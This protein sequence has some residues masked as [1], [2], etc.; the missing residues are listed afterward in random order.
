MKRYFIFIL[1]A[2]LLFVSCKS[3]EPEAIT[4]TESITPIVTDIVEPKDPF[5]K[6][7][8][9]ALIKQKDDR[10]DDNYANWLYDNEKESLFSVLE[11]TNEY[12]DRIWYE[13]TGSSFQ[14][15]KHLSGSSEDENVYVKDIVGNTAHLG[16]AGDVSFAPDYSHA[17]AYANGGL[18]N[19]FPGDIQNAMTTPDIFMVNNEFCYSDR[20]APQ[21]GKTYTFRAPP[22]R[23]NWLFEMGVDIVS[24][25]NNHAFDYG[26]DAFYDTLQTL[27][28]ANMPYIGGGYNL[29]DA[30]KCSYFIIGGMKIA[31]I[32]ATEIEGVGT[33]F[34]KGATED[35][36]GLLRFNDPSNLCDSIKYA[37]ENSDFVIVLPH[38]GTERIQPIQEH[39]HYMAEILAEAG[40]DVIIGGHPHVI[41]G[42]ERIN[43]TPVFYSLGN[44]SF[45]DRITDSCILYLD[46]NIDGIQSARFLP[47]IEKAGQ[48]I[49]VN[50]GSESYQRIIGE[51]NEYSAQGVT[52]DDD[53]FCYY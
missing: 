1:L 10:I 52:V 11:D 17:I 33:I 53:G 4:D 51:F 35:S 48:T 39:E 47:C 12:N 3:K 26:A 41:Q 2:S 43:E 46:I 9:I 50:K 31:Y 15:L 21:P 14:V 8:A 29:E 13:K 28:N 42:V 30:K 37:K 18:D 20:G 34:S 6:D 49:L 25:A 16:F 27:D 45:N 7:E 40:A 22:E 23:V 5:E 44:F 24:L 38:W 36:P 32:S 19:A